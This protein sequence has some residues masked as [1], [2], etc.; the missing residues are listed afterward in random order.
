MIENTVMLKNF[1][2]SKVYK[3]DVYKQQKDYMQS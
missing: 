1:Q 2:V 3:L